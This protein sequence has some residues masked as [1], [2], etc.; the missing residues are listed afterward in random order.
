MT[1]ISSCGK[2]KRFHLATAV[3]HLAQRYGAKIDAKNWHIMRGWPDFDDSSTCASYYYLGGG[4]ISSTA[5]GVSTVSTGGGA[6]A[7]EGPIIASVSTLNPEAPPFTPILA[8]YS[9]H[10]QMGH[11]DIS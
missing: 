7:P 4:A 5:S 11:Y 3:Y 9:H 8:N 2:Y 1:Y 6:P 10:C